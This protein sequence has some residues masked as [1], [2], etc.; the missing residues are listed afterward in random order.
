MKATN[1]MMRN[2]KETRMEIKKMR[3]MKKILRR[4]TKSQSLRKNPILRVKPLRV[5]MLRNLNAKT[6][7]VYELCSIT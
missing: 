7:D 2:R 4:R 1:N 6:N 5:L 3:K